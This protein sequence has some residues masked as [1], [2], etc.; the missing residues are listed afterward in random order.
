M[1]YVIVTSVR[2]FTV[3]FYIATDDNGDLNC[4]TISMISYFNLF[5]FY[6]SY[7]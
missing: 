5:S 6:S 4:K 1:N 7:F 3:F 2:V